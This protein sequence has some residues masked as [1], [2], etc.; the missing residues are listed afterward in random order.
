[1][2]KNRKRGF[3]KKIGF[4]IDV[5]MINLYMVNDSASLHCLI[6]L[7]IIVYVCLYLIRLLDM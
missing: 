7:P 1:M 4:I 3:L 2:T 6:I 5:V